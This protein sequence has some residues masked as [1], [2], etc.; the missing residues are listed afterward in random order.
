MTAKKDSLLKKGVLKAVSPLTLTIWVVITSS[1][2]TTLILISC[3]IAP[4][5]T[6]N[7]CIIILLRLLI[8]QQISPVLTLL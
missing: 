4:T 8:G 6:W 7:S 1:L 2:R 5:L 3:Y